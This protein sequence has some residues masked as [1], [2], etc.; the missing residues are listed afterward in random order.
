MESKIIIHSYECGC[1]D[2]IIGDSF[3]VGSLSDH[4]LLQIF[5]GVLVPVNH[6]GLKSI[7]ITLVP[8]SISV[9]ATDSPAQIKTF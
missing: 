8:N 1:T 6:S 2:C 9:L 3:P 7:Q 4:Q 5:V